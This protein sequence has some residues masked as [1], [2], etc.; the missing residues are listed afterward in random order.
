[1]RDFRGEIYAPSSRND[2]G[3]D[4][5]AALSRAHMRYRASSVRPRLCLCGVSRAHMQHTPE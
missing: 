2:D 4:V 5:N 1:M 3:R